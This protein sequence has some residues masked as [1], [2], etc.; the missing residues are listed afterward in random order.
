LK[1]EHE[2]TEIGDN[3]MNISPTSKAID[4]KAQALIDQFKELAGRLSPQARTG[5]PNAEDEEIMRQMGQMSRELSQY[6][7]AK[8]S[9]MINISAYGY[10]VNIRVNGK[11]I[12]VTGGG[13]SVLRLFNAN[14]LMKLISAPNVQE[15]NFVLNR[16]ENNITITYK[17]NG[18]GQDTLKVELKAPGY[19]E[20]LLNIS[21]EDADGTIEKKIS[22]EPA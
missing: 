18:T 3:T 7:A 5:E 4:P 16:G 12:G 20:S 15:K 9:V 13:S 19:S 22:I 2:Y 1:K 17:K 14:S 10:D 8:I 21:T 11:D 6:D